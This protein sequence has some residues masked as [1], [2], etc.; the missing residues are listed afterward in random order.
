MSQQ[1]RIL[2][3]VCV[4]AP[5]Y[6]IL[7]TLHADF[8]AVIYRRQP[9]QKILYRRRRLYRPR[10]AFVFCKRHSEMQSFGFRAHVMVAAEGGDYSDS[11]VSSQQAH[12]L[13]QG[14]VRIIFGYCHYRIDKVFGVSVFKQRQYRRSERVIHSAVQLPS[15]QV[16]AFFAVA[17]FCAGVFPHFAYQSDIA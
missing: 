6:G 7:V 10:R 16:A 15:E 3:T 2:V 14:V 9:R 11:I 17:D 13:I 4:R 1:L 12:R 5:V 8:V